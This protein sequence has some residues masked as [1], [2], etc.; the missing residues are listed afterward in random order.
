MSFIDWL[1]DLLGVEGGYFDDPDSTATNAG[2]RQDLYDDYR[3]A[4]GLVPRPVTT[5]TREDE[6]AFYYL[7]YWCKAGCD[8]VDGVDDRL[9]YVLFDAAVNQG[10]ETAAMML[11][12]AVGAHVDGNIGPATVAAIRAADTDRTTVIIR[13]LKARLARYHSGD[14]AMQAGWENRLRAVC[15]KVGIAKETIGL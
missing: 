9:A 14:P 2:V 6:R 3:K 10:P 15:A 8:L 1:P 11:Q 12:E 13:L 5:L 4:L 7:A